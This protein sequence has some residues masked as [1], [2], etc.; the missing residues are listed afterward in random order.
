M[1]HTHTCISCGEKTPCH[2]GE[3]PQACTGSDGDGR[4]PDCARYRFDM[5]SIDRL[6]AAQDAV[7]DTMARET[8]LSLEHSF[9]H[10]GRIM[11]VLGCPNCYPRP[12][13]P[14]TKHECPHCECIEEGPYYQCCYCETG[15]EDEM[16]SWK[17]K[18]GVVREQRLSEKAKLKGLVN[19]LAA[20]VMHLDA[21]VRVQAVQT[22]ELAIARFWTD[23]SA[24][25]LLKLVEKYD[26]LLFQEVEGGYSCHPS[27][28]RLLV[29]ES[30]IFVA[31]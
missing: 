7:M 12:E 8:F 20:K 15:T 1:I 26:N 17:R 25:A 14:K 27:P 5:I 31:R 16:S 18:I 9:G 4:C 19:Q 2:G 24:V 6:R 11:P 30:R 3:D 28:P 29:E 21:L 10:E 22:T 13:R 23:V